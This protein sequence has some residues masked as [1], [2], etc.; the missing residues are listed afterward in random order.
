MFDDR[1]INEV[2]MSKLQ[3]NWVDYFYAST[4]FQ[5]VNLEFFNMQYTCICV[6]LFAFY[7]NAQLIH[8][9]FWIVLWQLKTTLNPILIIVGETQKDTQ[10]VDVEPAKETGLAEVKG[11]EKVES[12]I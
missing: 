1:E 4:W 11:N 12:E 8:I 3:I 5:K 10:I 7:F 9:T 2:I 6:F